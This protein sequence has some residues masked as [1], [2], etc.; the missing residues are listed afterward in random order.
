VRAVAADGSTQTVFSKK[1][2]NRIS[3]TLTK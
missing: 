3:L 2:G 1:L